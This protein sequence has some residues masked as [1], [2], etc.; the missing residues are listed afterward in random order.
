MKD[1]RKLLV[2][3][4][5]RIIQD[6]RLEIIYIA[7]GR[8]YVVQAV[9][10]ALSARQMI[11]NLSC[12]I[13]CSECP[14]VVLGPGIEFRPFPK[15]VEDPKLL[16]TMLP[17]LSEK[18][19]SMFVDA[20][21]IFVGD[22]GE[23][24]QFFDFFDVAARL[25]KEPQSARG[26]GDSPVLGDFIASQLPHW[27]SGV[28]LFRNSHGAVKFFE[29]WRRNYL[30]MGAAFDQIS[31]VKTIIES[32]SKFLSLDYRWNAPPAMISSLG[33]KE[34]V[35]HYASNISD[36]IFDLLVALESKLYPGDKSNSV[37]NFVG[38]RRR[39]KGRKLGLLRAAGS[40]VYWKIIHPIDKEYAKLLYAAI[41]NLDDH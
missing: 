32:R 7:R 38:A 24:R 37:S 5:A 19:V 17:T 1:T 4:R 22:L 13:F 26:K 33:G 10:S 23:Y 9:L 28:I 40:K 20:D 6:V 21:T 34:I 16:K 15:N 29:D 30:E 14:D 27:N 39:Q 35:C 12:R 11:G 31:F 25:N 41:R 18:D 2:R 8:P 3:R 36:R